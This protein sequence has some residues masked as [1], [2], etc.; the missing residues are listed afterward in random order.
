MRQDGFTLIEVLVALAVAAI[1]L[2]ALSQAGGRYVATQSALE[3]R[4]LARWLAENEIMR[5]RSHRQR[6]LESGQARTFAGRRW[7]IETD[8]TPTAVPG[9]MRLTLRVYPADSQ[10]EAASL[11]TIIAP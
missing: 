5:L 6:R 4:V 8:T 7:R 11:T 10:Y 3:T 1:A 9:M 2:V